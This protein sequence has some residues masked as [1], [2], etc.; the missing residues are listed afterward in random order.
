M[1]SGM[2]PV[3]TLPEAEEFYDGFIGLIIEKLKIAGKVAIANEI[4]LSMH[5][6]QYTVLGSNNKDVVEHNYNNLKWGTLTIK[7]INVNPPKDM[8]Y[9]YFNQKKYYVPKLVL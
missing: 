2:L 9:K 4:R 1:T 3:Y 6:G 8:Q 5:P 7:E